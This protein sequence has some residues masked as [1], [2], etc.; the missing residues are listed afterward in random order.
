MITKKKFVEKNL[1]Q[2][3][4]S[5]KKNSKKF[6]KIILAIFL[7]LKKNSVEIRLIFEKKKKIEKNFENNFCNF[8]VFEKKVG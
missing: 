4:F 7:Y 3:N 5:K 6:F 1:R 2:K 8:F